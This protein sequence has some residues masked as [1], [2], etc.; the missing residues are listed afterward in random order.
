M[1]LCCPHCRADLRQQRVRRVPASA[2][3][4]QHY[5][6]PACDGVMMLNPHPAEKLFFPG[7][8]IAIF[9]LNL[10]SAGSGIKLSIEGAAIM[11]VLIFAAAWAVRH[12][13]PAGDWPRYQTGK[14]ERVD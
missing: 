13:L 14:A 9:A 10:Y 4:K 8:L 1:N 5:L 6:C 11:L 3:F 7:V 2:R 12:W